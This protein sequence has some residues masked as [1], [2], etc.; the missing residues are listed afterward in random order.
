MSGYNNDNDQR[1]LGTSSEESSEAYEPEKAKNNDSEEYYDLPLAI[2]S[3]SLIWAVI[4][5]AAGIL[6]LALS[7]FYYVGYVFSGISL[8]T[9]LISRRNLGFFE[10]Y[11]IMGII[12]GIIGLVFST[13]SLIAGLLGLFA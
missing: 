9:A 7:S 5:F 8:A 10:K 1:L 13:F 11:S 2:R 6:S 4:A 3:R 12:L